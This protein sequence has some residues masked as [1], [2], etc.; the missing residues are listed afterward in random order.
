MNWGKVA[1]AA[2][3]LSTAAAGAGVWY[4]QVYG[5]YDRIEADGPGAQ[6]NT[7]SAADGTM[8]PLSLTDFQGIDAS[9]SPLR[10]R[11]CFRLTSEPLPESLIPYDG[12]TPLNGPG[13]FDC[14][15]ADQIGH[16]LASGAAVAVLGTPEIRPDVDR[17]LAI[18][19]D[20]RAYGWHQ[21]NDKT[22]ERGVMD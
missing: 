16:D 4:A 17:V 18:Y 7:Q 13:W 15:D 19:P 12:A 5:F 21:Y 3:A 22:P 9:S 1:V 8:M 14:Y 6:I 11:A 2:L 20:G 10:W